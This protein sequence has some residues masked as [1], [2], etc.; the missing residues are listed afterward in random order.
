MSVGRG[1]EVGGRCCR[2]VARAVQRRQP[3]LWLSGPS[4]LGSMVVDADALLLITVRQIAEIP[5]GAP[6]ALRMV[7][8]RVSVAMFGIR[9][10]YYKP[11]GTKVLGNCDIPRS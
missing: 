1:A 11:W 9:S 7:T 3:W 4:L 5:L 10:A 2:G 8:G 6:A